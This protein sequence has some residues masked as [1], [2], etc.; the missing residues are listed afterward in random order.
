MSS[1]AWNASLLPEQQQVEP[2][3]K[4]EQ[5]QRPR[6]HVRKQER[7]AA[8]GP[9]PEVSHQP[10]QGA[11]DLPGRGKRHHQH[12]DRVEERPHDHSH[13]DQPLRRHAA[14][15]AGQQEDRERRKRR[16]RGR[17][18]AGGRRRRPPAGTGSP[19]A[20]PRPPRPRPR[21]CTDRRGGCGAAPGRPRRRTPA[22]RPPAVPRSARGRRSERTTRA[23]VSAPPRSKA[24][25]NPPKETGTG[26]IAAERATAPASA[27]ASAARTVANRALPA[28]PRLIASPPAG[29]C[30]ASAAAIFSSA[31]DEA[32]PRPRDEVAVDAE[33]GAVPEGGDL[34]PRRHLR[35]EPLDA[36]PSPRRRSRPAA[37]RPGPRRTGAGSGP[38]KR[39]A[40]LRAPASRSSSSMNVP[41]PATMMGDVETT[42]RASGAFS[43]LPGA[44]RRGR[45][46]SGVSARRP[47]RAPARRRRAARPAARSSRGPRAGPAGATAK[48]GIPIS[49]SARTL[50]RGLPSVVQ[51]TRSGDRATIRSTSGSVTPPILGREEAAG[52]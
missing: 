30:P 39:R 41:F 21:G 23:G 11:R 31:V 3:G 34:L 7:H 38:R 18:R 47:P 40:A 13:Q 16:A 24:S 44:P 10:V 12:D 26:P 9:L 42:N 49:S 22:P 33:H 27:A 52:G 51:S 45:R 2:A 1:P 35:G 50:C 19:R 5:R 17:R 46:P 32:R 48:Q 8:R 4:Q 28:G 43:P 6:R 37:R 36:R 15:A 29:A 25:T 14:A 20:P